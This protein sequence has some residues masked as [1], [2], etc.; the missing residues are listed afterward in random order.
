MQ[1][2]HCIGNIYRIYTKHSLQRVPNPLI[3][4]RPP[5]IAYLLFF[6]L[7]LSNLKI[8]LAQR[9]GG[10]LFGWW[11]LNTMTELHFK[12]CTSQSWTFTAYV[13]KYFFWKMASW[14]VFWWK[15]SHFTNDFL[16]NLGL[17]TR[18]LKN[19]LLW[20]IIS[21]FTKQTFFPLNVLHNTFVK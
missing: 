7:F 13:P 1:M 20:K 17:N 12:C 18:W 19:E 14:F 11:T 9:V 4:W 10:W 3:L 5:Y 6:V 8:V 16:F 15:L 21:P 2:N